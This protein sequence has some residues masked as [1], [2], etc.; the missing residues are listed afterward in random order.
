MQT[1]FDSTI[2]RVQNLSLEPSSN[3]DLIPVSK[4]SSL[5][6]SQTSINKRPSLDDSSKIIMHIKKEQEEISLISSISQPKLRIT[7]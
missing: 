4:K 1:S 2:E 6:Y 3:S 7:N 5:S